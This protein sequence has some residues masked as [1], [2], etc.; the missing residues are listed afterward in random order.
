[1]LARSCPRSSTRAGPSRL[2]L[3]EPD[4]SPERSGG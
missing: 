4:V 3:A 1:V 2:A